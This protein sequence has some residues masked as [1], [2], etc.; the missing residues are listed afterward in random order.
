MHVK[1]LINFLGLGQQV[2]AK[3]GFNKNTSL[4]SFSQRRI[5]GLP[6]P[7]CMLLHY[8]FCDKALLFILLVILCGWILQILEYLIAVS[9][10]SAHYVFP[11]C[12]EAC[13]TMNGETDSLL[14]ITST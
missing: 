6:P 1:I 14:F 12:F 9:L 13:R 3:L 2:S 7:F 8:G 10:Y 5:I 4:S 11:K